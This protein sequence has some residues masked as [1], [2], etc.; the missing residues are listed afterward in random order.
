MLSIAPSDAEIRER[1][2]MMNDNGLNVT[3]N[4]DRK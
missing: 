2:K 3:W 4:G 1:I